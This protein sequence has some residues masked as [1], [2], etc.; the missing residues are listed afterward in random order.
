MLVAY[1][2]IGLREQSVQ[3]YRRPE[4]SSMQGSRRPANFNVDA[5]VD[6]IAYYQAL[7]L[8]GCSE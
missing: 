4:Y 1:V 6:L 7:S 2:V 8:V 5:A 3:Q